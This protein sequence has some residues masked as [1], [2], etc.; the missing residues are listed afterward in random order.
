MGEEDFANWRLN[1]G[2]NSLFFNGSSKG[3]LGLARAGGVIFYP[4]GNKQK[5]YAWGL[6]KKSNNGVEWLALIKGLEIAIS[7]GMEELAIYGD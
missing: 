5:D 6:G 7:C 4:G 2:C 1:L 3:N